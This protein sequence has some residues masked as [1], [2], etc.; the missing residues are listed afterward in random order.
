MEKD[1]ITPASHLTFLGNVMSCFFS[2][3]RQSQK[4]KKAQ[5]E[6]AHDSHQQSNK[7]SEDE[8]DIYI[9]IYIYAMLWKKKHKHA[10]TWPCK[11]II[12]DRTKAE[13]PESQC[14][15]HQ[16]EKHWSCSMSQ[17]ASAKRQNHWPTQWC[18][19][20]MKRKPLTPNW[21]LTLGSAAGAQPLNMLD[22]IRILCFF[23]F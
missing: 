1:Y 15:C 21:N 4:E 10:W 9:Y 18:Q 20:R 11:A 19:T 6:C 23:F 17:R 2:P 7:W 22:A 8:A 16:L 12:G 5:P 14:D 13:Q 3:W